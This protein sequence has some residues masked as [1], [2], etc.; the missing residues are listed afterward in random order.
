MAWLSR[1]RF[2]CNLLE[3]RKAARLGL[4][5]FQFNGTSNQGTKTGSNRFKEPSQTSG[6]AIGGTGPR[7][8]SALKTCLRSVDQ[9]FFFN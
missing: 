2:R 4:E 6:A 9:N 3:N 1:R 7:R 8:L 5:L